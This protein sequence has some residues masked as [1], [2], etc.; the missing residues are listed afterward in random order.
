[1]STP[2][3][4]PTAV[5][6][7]CA[8]CGNSLAI[9]VV[10]PECLGTRAK[11]IIP[12]LNSWAAE[13]FQREPLPA[14]ISSGS[15]KYKLVGE[16][17]PGRGLSTSVYNALKRETDPVSP[18]AITK[19]LMESGEYQKAAPKA[20]SSAHPEVPVRALLDKWVEEGVVARS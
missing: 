3:I 5:F 14:A 2:T 6:T 10:C 20:A 7:F 11:D 1:M 8:S 19:V 13:L 4:V 12:R 15:T 16:A 17:K 9:L 18:E